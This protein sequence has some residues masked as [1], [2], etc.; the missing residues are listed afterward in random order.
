MPAPGSPMVSAAVSTPNA[1]PDAS[2][3]GTSPPFGMRTW[4]MVF[5]ITF[6]SDDFYREI[7]QF[8]VRVRPHACGNHTPHVPFRTVAISAWTIRFLRP[9]ND[10]TTFDSSRLTT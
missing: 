6:P 4:R 2:C 7:I 8:H 5:L 3:Y 1:T 10:R 9:Y